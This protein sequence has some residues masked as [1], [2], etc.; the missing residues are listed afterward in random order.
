[1]LRFDAL[2]CALASALLLA[3]CAGPP[4]GSGPV[5]LGPGMQA[6]YQKYRATMQ[7][8]AFAISADGGV[9]YT[10]CNSLSGCRG[11]EVAQALASCRR[12]ARTPCYLYDVNGKVVWQGQVATAPE[13]DRPLAGLGTEQ[14]RNALTVDC[15]ERAKSMSPEDRTM[16]ATAMSVRESRVPWAFCDRLI[17]AVARGDLA[18]EDLAAAFAEPDQ[19]LTGRMIKALTTPGA[20]E[21]QAAGAAP[22]APRAQNP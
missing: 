22:P 7:P 3:G 18:R 5:R 16:L 19:A 2:A 9:G 14:G 10:W 1:M 17:S 21:P 6:A 13:P 11:N 4:V 8:G 12:S 20:T 15:A